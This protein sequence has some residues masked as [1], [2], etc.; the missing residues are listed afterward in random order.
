MLL[1][2]LLNLKIIIKSQRELMFHLKCQKNEEEASRGDLP[3]SEH[4][5]I[6]IQR[7]VLWRTKET[8]KGKIQTNV[9]FEMWINGF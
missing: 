3:N 8:T 1:I 9:N 5:L 4:N 7:I 2:T 6:A